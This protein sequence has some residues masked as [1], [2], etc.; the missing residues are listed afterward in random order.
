MS[1]ESLILFLQPQDMLQWVFFCC[2]FASAG[3]T[4]V[5][6][7]L[8]AT[9]ATWERNW[10]SAIGGE[11]GF[12]FET[13]HGSVHDIS[14]AVASRWERLAES[15]P[16]ILLVIGLLGTFV[17]LGLAL[18]EAASVVSANGGASAIGH[19]L[20]GLG[21]KFKSSTWGIIAYLSFRAWVSISDFD[22]SR[23]RWCAEKMKERLDSR[24][25]E[26]EKREV[27][28]HVRLI[29]ATD[30][31]GTTVARAINE[32]GKEHRIILGNLLGEARASNTCLSAISEDLA[33]QSKALTSFLEVNSDNLRAIQTSA[34]EMGTAAA[35]VGAAAT[36][37][38]NV[39]T[40]LKAD[41][42]ESINH[43]NGSIKTNLEAVATQ[44]TSAAE[45]VSDSASQLGKSVS[46][47]EHKVTNVLTTMETGLT[48]AIGA[49]N[50]SF[51]GNMKAM[52]TNLSDA[53]GKIATAV[54]KLPASVDGTMTRIESSMVGSVGAM[55]KNFSANLKEIDTS[56]STATKSITEAVSTVPQA[57][58]EVKEAIRKS[59]EIQTRANGKFDATSLSLR[60][61]VDEMKRFVDSLGGDIKLGLTAISKAVLEVSS[62]KANFTA[63]TTNA[64]TNSST[65]QTTSQAIAAIATSLTPLQASIRE[66]VVKAATTN[67]MGSKTLKLVG[68]SIDVNGKSAAAALQ[69]IKESQR[70][71][72][73]VAKDSL[74]ALGEIST[75]IKG[76]ATVVAELQQVVAKISPETYGSAP[77]LE[78]PATQ[79][80]APLHEG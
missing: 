58:D 70:S 7:R 49:M 13:E 67:E 56:L 41:L 14:E 10:K 5:F 54:Q 22:A 8:R 43:M 31:V 18:N 50:E 2:I 36:Q 39:I 4:V 33:T 78:S 65:L 25:A 21:T 32:S 20:D 44:M 62:L 69:T 79:P 9:P 29:E 61:T 80:L 76:L 15:M 55:Q 45:V 74:H 52:A 3:L 46:D 12:T 40:T 77:V 71:S 38:G 35:S 17:G 57:M 53:A 1:R 68:E 27:A 64:E 42:T 75:G 51:N 24:R 34:T 72:A 28:L 23:M 63:I 11:T 66:F 60:E 30:R 6:V 37:L 48:G 47:F 73:I 16:G 19:T 59:V 26:L